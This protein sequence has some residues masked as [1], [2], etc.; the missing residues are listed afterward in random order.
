M[1]YSNISYLKVSGIERMHEITKVPK[2]EDFVEGV[3]ILRG[4]VILVVDL[5]K[6]FTVSASDETKETRIVFVDIHGQPIGCLVDAVIE[7][8]RIPADSV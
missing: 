1:G 8:L 5:R 6:V 4:R 7:V 2:T 3:I